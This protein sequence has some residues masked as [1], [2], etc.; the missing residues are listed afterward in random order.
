MS[1]Q[2]QQSEHFNNDLKTVINKKILILSTEIKTKRKELNTL[3][4]DLEV[5]NRYNPN[6][7]TITHEP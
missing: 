7:L 4:K 1:N 2:K 6:Q 3:K 5:I